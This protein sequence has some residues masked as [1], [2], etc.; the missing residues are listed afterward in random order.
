M[1]GS[2]LAPPSCLRRPP[3]SAPGHGQGLAQARLALAG[4]TNQEIGAELFIS[5]RTV[6]WHLKKVF[7]KLGI[8]SRKGLRDALPAR[9]HA[10]TAG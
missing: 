2:D 10:V 3:G 7:M 8:S 5:A 9:G 4:R 6:E 1:A